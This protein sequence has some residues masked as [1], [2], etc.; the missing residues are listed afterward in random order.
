MGL[1]NFRIAVFV[2]FLMNFLGASQISAQEAKTV[3]IQ[4]GIYA[5]VSG[6][7]VDS[8]S[9]F[10]ITRKGVIVVD[11][12]PTPIEANKVLAEIRK[13][14]DL[15][16]IYTINTHFHGDHTFGNQVFDHNP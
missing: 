6:Q 11:T 10:I 7:G 9:T 3:F 16:I 4:K 8:N 1:S 15:P 14:T 13:H 2:V 12:R 5:M